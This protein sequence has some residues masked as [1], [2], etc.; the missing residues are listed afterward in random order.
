MASRT[1]IGGGNNRADNPNGWSSSGVPLPGDTLDMQSGVMNI[2]DN[3]LAGNTLVIGQPAQSATTTLN[4]SHH[5]SVSIDIAQQSNADVTVNVK[6]SDTLNVHTEFPSDGHFT[7]NLADH[8][9]LTGAFNMTFSSA[10]IDG[11]HDSRF[12]GSGL[13]LGSSVKINTQVKGNGSFAVQSAQSI[14]GQV[15]F[16]D[17]V[18]RGE[19]VA[20][21]GDPFRDVTSRVQI[22]QPGEF[23]GSVALGVF[24]E[25]DLMGLFKASSYAI[26]H[27][28]LSIF[29]GHEVIDTLRLTTPQGPGVPTFAI[30]VAQ[31]SMGVVVD[32]GPFSG[33]GTLLPVH[34]QVF[35]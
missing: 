31:T 26:K 12:M 6:G 30:N 14:G 32:H 35:A 29:S 2:R 5:A 20:V 34:S 23:K 1:W 9:S 15:E 10:V 3:D 4:L 33:N 17:S 21:S 18:S 25:V 16:G 19:S 28:I 11:G 22:D 8:A 24:G 13:L 7:I 27:D